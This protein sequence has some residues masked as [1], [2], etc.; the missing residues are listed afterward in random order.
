LNTSISGSRRLISTAALTFMIAASA[1][2]SPLQDVISGYSA[3]AKMNAV[4]FVGFSADRGRA[5]FLSRS[6]TGKPETSSC[7]S[8]HSSDPKGN[9]ETRAGKEIAPMALSKTPE[10]YGDPKKVEKWFRRN[11]K[12]VLGRVCT[13]LEKGDFLTFMAS[14]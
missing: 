1:S 6:T 13:S 7:T 9:G 11:C 4:T 14:Q 3:E 5:L 10:R 8:C 2:A 12:S